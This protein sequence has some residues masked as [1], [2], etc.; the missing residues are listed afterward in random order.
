MHKIRY[1]IQKHAFD[2][3][4]HQTKNNVLDIN[5]KLKNKASISNMCIL[6]QIFLPLF[7]NHQQRGKQSKP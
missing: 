7:V 5:G 2:T 3:N 6:T 4:K 1:Q